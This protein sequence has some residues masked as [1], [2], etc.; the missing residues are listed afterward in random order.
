[1]ARTSRIALCLTLLASAVAMTGPA[2]ARGGFNPDCKVPRLRL[3]PGCTSDVTITVLLNHE[4]HINFGS[5]GPMHM[6]K[7]LVG[8]KH[9]QY[10]A[11]NETKTSYKPNADFVGKDYFEARF[12]FEMMNGSPA[13]AVLKAAVD[14][15][16]H[17]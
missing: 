11:A 4:C 1:M 10:W 5:L 17:F 9:G 16:P 15:V 14:V 3:C 8:P 13:S 6:P 7:I 2:E 12:E